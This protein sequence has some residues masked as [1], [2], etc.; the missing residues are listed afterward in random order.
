MNQTSVL[1]SFIYRV[2]TKSRF[3][4]ALDQARSIKNDNIK[5]GPRKFRILIAYL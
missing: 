1:Q 3:F 5:S 2:Q 4:A